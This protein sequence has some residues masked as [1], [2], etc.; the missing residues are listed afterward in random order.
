MI[1]NV[2]VKPGSSEQK[3]FKIS[4]N[5]FLILLKSKPENNKANIEMINL[6]SKYFKVPYT[7]IK[8]KLGLTGLKKTVELK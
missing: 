7:K 4:E 3:I 1:I 5:K 6:I 8:I 2:R